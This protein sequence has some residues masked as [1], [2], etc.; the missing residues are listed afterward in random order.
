MNISYLYE[1]DS[2]DVELSE[3]IRFG[4]KGIILLGTEMT[5]ETAASDKP[6]I[7]A[8]SFAVTAMKSPFP[9]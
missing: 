5:E 1:G 6:S 4:C 8:S 3:I 9:Y 2:I 7:F